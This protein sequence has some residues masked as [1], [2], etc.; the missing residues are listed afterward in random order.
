MELSQHFPKQETPFEQLVGTREV[1]TRFKCPDYQCNY[2]LATLLAQGMEMNKIKT[3]LHQLRNAVKDCQ[4]ND[5]SDEFLLKWLKAHDFDVARATKMLRQT[6]E[7][8]RVNGVDKLLDTFKISDVMKKYFSVGRVGVDKYG[9]PLYVSAMG[10]MDMKGILLSTKKNELSEMLIYREEKYIKAAREERERTGRPIATHT[11]IFDFDHLS[12]KQLTCKPVAFELMAF[13]RLQL[14][15][16]PLNLRRAFIINA[17]KL[18]FQLLFAMLNPFLPET[19]TACLRV[20]GNDKT[21]WTSALLEEIDAD[22]IPAFYGGTMTDPDGDPK[23]PS[24]FNMGGEVPQS[25]YLCNN[26]PVAKK[27]METLHVIAGVGGRKKLKYKIEIV[28][29]VMRWEFMTEG[30]DIEFRVYNSNL[31]DEEDLL[32][33]NRVDS[34]LVMEEGELTCHQPGKYIFEFSNTF[35]YLKTKKVYYHITVHPQS[36]ENV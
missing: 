7:W 11:I 4:L 21:Q 3:A 25:Y 8:R 14:A 16:Y 36:S 1:G 29:S 27:Y 5:S 32:P 20:F 30:G 9:C 34:H 12:M 17:P 28:P 23:C 2:L 24:K 35:S 31:N 6:L 18:S 13:T 22:Q 10:R 26:A 33:P 15:H 19:A